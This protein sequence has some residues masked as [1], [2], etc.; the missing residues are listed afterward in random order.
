MQCK[1]H[2]DVTAVD[3]CAGCAEPFCGDCLVDIHGQKYCGACKTMALRGA[4]PVIA[5]EA[6]IPCKEASEAL[7]YAIIGLFCFGIIL[8]PVAISKALKA[9]KMMELNPR[10]T[11]SGK[12]TAAL[13]IAVI[14]LLLWI[15]GLVARVASF[16]RQ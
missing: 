6:T 13:I 8:E 1:N 15:L 3:R 9:K 7:T 12:V 2:P 5:E 14:G 16:G 4:G 11:G 10:L